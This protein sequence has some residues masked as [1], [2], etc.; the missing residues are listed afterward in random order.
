MN[1]QA[2]ISMHKVAEQYMFKQ[3]VHAHAINGFHD[4]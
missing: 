3:L 2:N 1:Q 4:A